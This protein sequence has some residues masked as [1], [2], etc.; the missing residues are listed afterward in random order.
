MDKLTDA[1]L[2]QIG[3]GGGRFPGPVEI[4]VRDCESKTEW[5]IYPL[6]SIPG[7]GDAVTITMP[8][9]SE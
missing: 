1:F 6:R 7:L 8:M 2:A 5:L 4:V 9:V 3:D